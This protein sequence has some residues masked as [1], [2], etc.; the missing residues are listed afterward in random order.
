M[1]APFT[2]AGAAGG[3]EPGPSGNRQQQ[4]ARAMT[5]R[6]RAKRRLLMP[7]MVT[8]RRALRYFLQPPRDL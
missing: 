2:A 6:I 3:R 7:D 1:Q 5:G 8:R 4:A